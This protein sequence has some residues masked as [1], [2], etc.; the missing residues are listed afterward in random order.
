MTKIKSVTL[1][2]FTFP[3]HNLAPSE[4]GS[5]IGGLFYAPGRKPIFPSR[6]SALR[7]KTGVAGTMC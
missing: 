6:L 7:P 2:Q 3:A 5:S 4:P 1:T